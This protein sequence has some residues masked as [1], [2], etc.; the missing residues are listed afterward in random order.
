MAVSPTTAAPTQ[1]PTSTP[2]ITIGYWYEKYGNSKQDDYDCVMSAYDSKSGDWRSNYQYYYATLADC[3]RLC[4]AQSN[5]RMFVDV[6]ELN[7]R[8]CAFKSSRQRVSH[9]DKDVYVKRVSQTTAAPTSAPT[10]PP[11]TSP[12][13]M[14]TASP[15]LAPTIDFRAQYCLLLESLF[16]ELGI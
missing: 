5:C 2:T 16:Q 15:T 8:F 10:S 11:A 12:T 6:R 3:E 7:P 14:P 13:S 9:P 4:S 1:A